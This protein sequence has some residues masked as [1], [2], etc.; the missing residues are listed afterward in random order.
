MAAVRSFCR[1]RRRARFAGA[2]AERPPG[3]KRDLAVADLAG[4]GRPHDRVDRVATLLSSTTTSTFTLGTKST[5]TPCR[6]TFRCGPSAGQSRG[7]R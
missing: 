6:G 3:R 7:L 2:D 4:L 1:H 5:G